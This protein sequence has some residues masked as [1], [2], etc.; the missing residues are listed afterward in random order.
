MS[1]EF[2]G[3]EQEQEQQV[4]LH[5]DDDASFGVPPPPEGEA[6]PAPAPPTTGDPSIDAVLLDLAAAQRGSLG[7][8]I[9]AGEVAQAALQSRLGDLGGA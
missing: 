6:G 7:D 5:R 1:T 4:S 8:R 3:G 9:T 2:T